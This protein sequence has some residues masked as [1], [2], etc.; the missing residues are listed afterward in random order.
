M[1]VQTTW[2]EQKNLWTN[3]FVTADT[4]QPQLRRFNNL[5]GRVVTVNGNMRCL[6]DFQD[7]AWYDIPPQ[8]LNLC[9][10]QEEA[11]KRYNAA[12]NSAQVA[13]RRQA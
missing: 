8:F 11:A 1:T 12:R 3:R 2:V 10:D 6:V 4:T 13:P 5:I 7:G 9:L